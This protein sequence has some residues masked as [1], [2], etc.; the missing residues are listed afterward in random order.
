MP[1]AEDQGAHG[2]GQVN[3]V[4]ALDIEDAMAGC[5]FRKNWRKG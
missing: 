1:V 4:A 2:Q 5:A 3:I